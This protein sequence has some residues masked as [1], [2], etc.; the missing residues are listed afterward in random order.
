MWWPEPGSSDAGVLR[1]VGITG[2]VGAEG[3]GAGQQAVAAANGL[4]RRGGVSELVGLCLLGELGARRT[5]A[6]LGSVTDTLVEADITRLS[7]T[8]GFITTP[9][10]RRPH[11]RG[12]APHCGWHPDPCDQACAGGSVGQP[13]HVSGCPVPQRG[14]LDDAEPRGEHGDPPTRHHARPHGGGGPLADRQ[15]PAPDRSCAGG[16]GKC[17]SGWTCPTGRTRRHRTWSITSG[18]TACPHPAPMINSPHRW[19]D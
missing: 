10:P 9:V 14:N 19:P 2:G 5:A 17:P 15:P 4:A 16:C 13:A 12:V 8:V 7:I 11:G 1:S 3:N 18:R 6:R